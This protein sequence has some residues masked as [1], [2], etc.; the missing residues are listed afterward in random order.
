MLKGHQYNAY[1]YLNFI[2]KK[3]S[4]STRKFVLPGFTNEINIYIDLPSK[5]LPNKYKDSMD[6]PNILLIITD[7]VAWHQHQ[8][9]P[10]FELKLPVWEK[11]C[12]EGIEFNNA[13][14][15]SPICTPA[16]A[17]IL[18]GLYPSRHGLRW[19]TEAML[20]RNLADF[21]KGQKLYSCYLKEAGYNNSYI[22]KWHCGSKLTAADFGLNGWSV[23]HYGQP[24]KTDK[25]REYIRNKGLNSPTGTIEHRLRHDFTG[26][27][28]IEEYM[29][30][31]GV[32]D[33]PM[34]GHHDHFIS[35]LAIDELNSLTQSNQPWSLTASYWGP[36]HAY[37]PTKDFAG[38]V[39]PLSI[40]V[41]PSFNED[42]SNKPF[43]YKLHTNIHR[44][45]EQWP[46]W[47]TWQKVIARAYEQQIQTDHAVGQL[48][49]ALDKSDQKDNT[50]VIWL[51]D[52][53][54]GIG[55]HGGSWDKACSFT[56]EI[57]RIPMAIRWPEKITPDQCF[58][59]TSN[60]DATPTILAAAGITMPDEV[61][62]LNLLR[63]TA[64]NCTWPDSRIFE[65]H[66]HGLELLQRVLVKN[67]F[68]Y[69][70]ALFDGDELYDLKS[71]PYELNNLI[72]SPE[73]KELCREMREE[74]IKHLEFTNDYVSKP[75]KH[76]LLNQ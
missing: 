29:D 64:K 46:E 6:R 55:A 47:S 36:H 33:G 66:G 62:G 31:A 12:R 54:D 72:H 60:I 44:A 65:H 69:C 17:S 20:P 22:G 43:R 16:R 40:A 19:N 58:K 48:L 35:S 59:L 7:H 1:E 71:D 15:V 13:Y 74:I 9:D 2:L 67:K 11:F 34:E 5:E 14:T 24:Y 68:K 8:T 28:S 63:L 27:G 42:L 25:Y 49:E 61:D 73:H 18:T 30:A 51:A 75:L 38:K 26:Q 37:F 10:N 57:T 41:Y 4:T 39:N 45:K 50:L 23:P 21:K 52:H 3:P 76:W 53:G 56:E 70:A 32:M